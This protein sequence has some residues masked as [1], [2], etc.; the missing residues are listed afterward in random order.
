[1][2]CRWISSFALVHPACQDPLVQ[3]G[4]LAM[5]LCTLAKPEVAFV[6]LLSHL[7]LQH[8]VL[9][10]SAVTEAGEAGASSQGREY[11]L[12]TLAPPLSSTQLILFTFRA[13]P[14]SLR[15]SGYWL[16]TRLFS[17]GATWRSLTMRRN[18]PSILLIQLPTTWTCMPCSRVCQA[19]A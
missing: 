13:L 7:L 10:Q 14:T 2:P 17:S 12:L 3:H 6:I 1:M 16:K 8:W 4:I 9:Q 5:Q 15:A 19:E 11:W 18:S